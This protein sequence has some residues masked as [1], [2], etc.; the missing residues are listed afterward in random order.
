MFLVWII[1]LQCFVLFS[2]DVPLPSE[3]D[4][5]FTRIFMLCIKLLQFRD[6]VAICQFPGRSAQ[7]GT[8]P[9]RALRLNSIL[10]LW[11][12]VFCGNERELFVEV[13]G[14]LPMYAQS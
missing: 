6:C 12:S 8:C 4:C 13:C 1:S 7:L 3:I 2:R 14:F 9:W 5:D 11:R 10:N